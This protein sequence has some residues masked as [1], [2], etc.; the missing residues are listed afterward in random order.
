MTL[1]EMLV[2]VAI[3]ALI[4]VSIIEFVRY[5]YRSNTVALEQAFAIESA[6]KGVEFLV[7]DIRE[8]TYA[9]TGAY[10]IA[11]FSTSTITFYADTDRDEDIER[12]RYYL[13]GTSFYRAVLEPTGTPPGYTGAETISEVSTS[14]RNN[15][16]GTDIFSY[17]DVNGAGVSDP[18]DIAAI[19]FVSVNLVV[20]IQPL[21][22]PD[23]FTLHSSAT[24]RNLRTQ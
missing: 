19:V 9:E 21:R 15:E 16:Q 18:A 23:E 13:D 22:A 2:A 4:I 1:V 24:I 10:P 17:Y 20:N 7:R 12:I 3:F 8:A 6:R 14:V 5:F 11:S